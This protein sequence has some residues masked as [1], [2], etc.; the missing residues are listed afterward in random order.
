VLADALGWPLSR[1]DTAMAS[2]DGDLTGRGQRVDVDDHGMATLRPCHGMLSPDQRIALQ[3]LRPAAA[4]G[5][6]DDVD[7]AR[8]LSVIALPDNHLTE[9][10]IALRAAIVALQQHGLAQRRHRAGHVELTDDSRFSLV[11]DPTTTD[12][13]MAPAQ[14]K[15]R[16]TH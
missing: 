11:L 16:R 1:L 2:L 6:D 12:I 8:A 3:R 7:L 9:N 15:R 5:P 4:V 10:D 13:P 14:S